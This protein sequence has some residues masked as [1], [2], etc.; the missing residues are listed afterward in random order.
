MIRGTRDCPRLS[1]FRSSKHTYA[2]IIDDDAGVTLC[3]AGTRDRE[4]REQVPNGGNIQAAKVIGKA[5]ADK[6]L[7][8]KIERVC[9]DR[10]GF[11][12]HGRVKELADAAR[13]CGLK[14]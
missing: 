11:R 4:L 5:L 6:A 12:F 14:F 7:A 13:E 8:K 10:N 3:Q 1:V 9:F 2:Q